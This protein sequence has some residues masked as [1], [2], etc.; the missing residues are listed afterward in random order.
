MRIV[1]SGSIGRL[2]LGGYAWVHMNYL[3]GLA[4][5]GHDVYY[6]EDC[7]DGSW[8]Y[9]WEAQ[10]LTT[11]L[12][13]P[14]EYVRNAVEPIG[15]GDRWMYRA[16]TEARGMD[17]EDFAEVCAAADLLLVW[18]TPL[19][20]WRPEYGLARRHAYIDADPGFT[21]V[22]AATGDDAL[23][24]AIARADR[25]F[26]FGQHIGDDGCRVPLLGREWV[27]TLPPVFL[28]LWPEV[29]AP[30]DAPLT[31]VVQWKGYGEF[32]YD[33]QRYGD[34]DSQLPPYLDIPLRTGR[35]FQMAVTGAELAPFAEGGWDPVPGWKASATPGT[36]QRFIRSSRAEFSVAKHGY[37]ASGGGWFSDRSV[38]YLASGRPVIVQDT[39]LDWLPDEGVLV[40]DSPDGAVAA[41]DRLE[42]DY[43]S[44]AH[45]ARRIAETV[46]AS[47]RVLSAL[48]E[49]L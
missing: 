3:A 43:D 4:A 14:A 16:G 8:V 38:C 23:A 22:K 19:G 1:F 17:P 32:E 6:L 48:L 33:G 45:A 34:K 30:T 29:P 39:G 27:K 36:Y 11:A 44:H 46:F 26:T 49:A 7:G 35:R 41:V 37:V 31:C 18:A 15:L 12:D 25:V 21:Q 24:E 5:L 28:P 47:H 20:C 2:P 40:F 13:Y 10:E 9:D 42:A